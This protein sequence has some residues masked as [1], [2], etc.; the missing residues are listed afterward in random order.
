MMCEVSEKQE[1]L[2]NGIIAEELFEERETA[3]WR[4]GCGGS[5]LLSDGNMSPPVSGMTGDDCEG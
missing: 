4:R 5:A 2:R 1:R 3:D